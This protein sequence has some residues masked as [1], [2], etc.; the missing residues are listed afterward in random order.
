MDKKIYVDGYLFELRDDGLYEA[1]D[2]YVIEDICAWV[3]NDSHAGYKL[4]TRVEFGRS[5]AYLLSLGNPD[6]SVLNEW[7][8]K[9]ENDKIAPYGV[10]SCGDKGVRLGG[11]VSW[12]T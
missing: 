9:Y 11:L 8:R 1:R 6:H 5:I 7:Y 3:L 10:L 4:I 2:V 12:I